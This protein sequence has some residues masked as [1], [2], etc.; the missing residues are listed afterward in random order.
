MTSLPDHSFRRDSA[1]DRSLET[2]PAFLGEGNEHPLIDIPFSVYVDGRQYSGEGLSLL[3]AHVKGL[4]DPALENQERLV[5]LSFDFGG[6]AVSLHPKVLIHRDSPQR[7]VLRF[8]EPTGD[9]L[10]QLRRILN[11]YISGDLTSLGTVIRAGQ[12][13]GAK[14]TGV[15]AGQPS[16]WEGLRRALGSL[17][18]LALALLLIA[19]AGLLVGQ[20]LLVTR[21][22]APAQVVVAGETLRAVADGQISYFDPAAPQGE[23]VFAIASTS[24]ET[25]SIAMP[26]D[27]QAIPAGVAEGSTVLAGEPI[28]TLVQG[29]QATVVEA[30]IPV[31]DLFALQEAGGA[32]VRLA[33]G[34]K[35]FGRLDDQGPAT[36]GEEFVQVR[37]VPEPALS[38]DLAGQVV[39]LRLRRDASSLVDRLTDGWAALT[40]LWT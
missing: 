15:R 29:E 18:M 30:A 7:L 1:S 13:I 19:T 9:H 17:A 4:M 37:L 10:P 26:C 20:R 36:A 5:R 6:F 8:T 12:P 16:R 14:T 27:C 32:E 2:P 28:L 40:S 33:D 31:G 34:S 22:A 38:T 23:V 3:E 21:L 25:L 35:V 39:E 11:D 24:G